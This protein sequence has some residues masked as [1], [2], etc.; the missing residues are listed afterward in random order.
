M[1]S[2]SAG[3]DAAELIQRSKYADEVEDIEL[4]FHEWVQG[5]FQN[6]FEAMANSWGNVIG[7]SARYRP[8]F[9]AQ[10]EDL[11]ADGK[12]EIVFGF[13]TPSHPGRAAII[14]ELAGIFPN[15]SESTELRNLDMMI[16]EASLIVDRAKRETRYS[17]IAA[18]LKD[19]ALVLP[20]FWIPSETRY[21]VR[22][23]LKG[24]ADPPYGGSRFVGVWLDSA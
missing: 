6:Q 23:G 13:A 14:E 2:G 10:Y 12:I 9:V 5:A 20:L 8:V 15:R 11:L 16:E 3:V 21:M 24:L 22:P 18:F 1:P 19:Q 7:V 17:E 4:T